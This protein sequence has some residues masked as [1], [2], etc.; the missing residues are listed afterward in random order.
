MI[1][2]GSEIPSVLAFGIGEEFEQLLAETLDVL[3][4]RF[5]CH[6]QESSRAIFRTRFAEQP[7]GTHRKMQ[8]VKL[9]PAPPN[10]MGAKIQH[11]DTS[12]AQELTGFYSRAYPDGYFIPRLL[13]M[14]KFVGAFVDGKLVSVAG[15][16][17]ASDQYKVAAL[18]NIATDPEFRGRKL[19]RLLT[20]ELARQFKSEGKL[21]CLNVKDNNAAAIRCYEQVG[22]EI[23]HSYE[24]ARFEANSPRQ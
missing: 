6:F 24:E 14:G 17:V 22:F 13:E 8:L 16:H 7:F 20:H 23:R 11:L 18:G 10:E 4:E 2:F 12:H 9:K 3:P 19:A 1:F 5:F 15:V 21:I